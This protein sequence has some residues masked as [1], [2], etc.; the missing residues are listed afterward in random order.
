MRR[1]TL[2]TAI[3]GAL[4][5][6][7]AATRATP[8]LAAGPRKVA[9]NFG[10]TYVPVGNAPI[11]AVPQAMG[12]W[13]QEGL[14][15]Q[16]QLANGVGSAVQQL[17]AG[18]VAASFGGLPPSMT[19]VN[20]GAKIVVAASLNSRNVYYPVALAS[21]SIKTV[22]DMKGAKIGITSASSS[23][24]FFIRAMLQKYGIN[25]DTGVTLIS[26]GS[27]PAA[28]QAL[29]SHRIDVLQLFEASYDQIERD[30]YPLRRFDD[31]AGF[32]DLTFT[33]GMTVQQD[34]MTSDPDLLTR[35]LRGMAKG[36]VYA[37]AHPQETVRMHWKTFPLSKPQ[38]MSDADALANDLAV[39]Q[40]ALKNYAL[41]DQNRFGEA[42]PEAV[43][44]MR[45]TMKTF[46]ELD[47]A[48]PVERYFDP[49]LIKPANEFDHD[50]IRAL[51]PR[52]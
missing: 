11:F 13:N 7:L 30:G 31:V 36:A 17:I 23:N 22:P 33:F 25:P 6:A 3:L 44:A 39:L 2:N 40:G 5:A 20:K 34:V 12:F 29:T 41:A 16:L 49:S 4:P 24:V 28:L 8:A 50:A 48:L 9:I 51:P 46:G 42:T 15:V 14:D 38:G 18:Q 37:R 52:I 35:I 21:S 10:L 27:G 19:L 26:V 45:D 1:R 32:N 47:A 43:T